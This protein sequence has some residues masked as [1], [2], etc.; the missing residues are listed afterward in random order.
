MEIHLAVLGALAFATAAAGALGGLGGAVILV[1][2][3]VL[4]GADPVDAAP[5]GLL[6]VAAGSLAA[7][8]VNLSEGVVHHRLGVTVE[9]VASAGAVGGAL[10][11]SS[12]PAAV[13]ARVLAV[14]A[15]A[16]GV[17]GAVRR[18]VRNPPEPAF[19]AERSGEWPGTLAGAYVLDDGVVPYAARRIRAG[20]ALMGLGGAIAGAT[21]VGGGFLKTPVMAEIMD[22]PIK[23]AAATTIFTVGIT[24][25]AALIV[26]AGDGRIDVHAGAAVVLAALAGGRAGAWLQTVLPPEV[27]R[28]VLSLLLL[29]VSV[30]L[31]VRGA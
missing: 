2:T 11:A 18:G 16:A 13:G 7:A 20:L 15:L 24:A 26:Y 17:A 8:P 30:V 4:L 31:G 1:P 19:S 23:V 3:L 10:M 21:G 28:R 12:L 5:L 29:V 14:T 27:V 9:I 22:I 6:T 25:G